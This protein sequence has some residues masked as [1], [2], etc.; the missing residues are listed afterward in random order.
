MNSGGVLLF[1]FSLL[2]GVRSSR[3]YALKMKITMST[4]GNLTRIFPFL[5][6]TRFSKYMLVRVIWSGNIIPQLKCFHCECFFIAQRAQ[7]R[8]GREK[9][10]QNKSKM[11][12]IF[13]HGHDLEFSVSFARFGGVFVTF[14]YYIFRL[15]TLCRDDMIYV[16]MEALPVTPPPHNGYL[17]SFFTYRTTFLFHLNKIISIIHS[18]VVAFFEYF[19]CICHCCGCI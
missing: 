16:V 6:G 1:L 4:A 2:C 15:T 9:K 8:R 11:H 10:G 7:E 3:K 13:S 19:L 18:R 12:E 5:A 14:P 17:F